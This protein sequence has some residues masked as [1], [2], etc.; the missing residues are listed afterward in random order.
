MANILIA[1]CGDL[2]AALGRMFCEN[3][4]QVWGIRRRA[5]AVPAPIK[6]LALDL[7]EPLDP[8]RLPAADVVFYTAAAGGADEEAY[9]RAY[10]LGPRHLIAALA[11]RAPRRIFFSSSTRVYH[12]SGGEWVDEQSPTRPLDFRGR[13][14]LRGEAEILGAPFPGTVVRFSGLYGP[15][16]YRLVVSAAAGAH[17]T[18]HPPV[19]GNRIHRRDAARVLVHLAALARPESIYLAS[20]SDPAPMHEVSTWIRERLR[21]SGV[22]DAPLG[23]TP[24]PIPRNSKRCRNQRLL[25][26]GFHFEYP[27]YRDG[28]A[29]IIEAWLRE[30]NPLLFNDLDG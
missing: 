15:G 26:G 7:A 18:I 5:E 20:D 2:G 24:G 30:N 27:S 11:A 16:R 9:H 23:A 19:Y 28:Y 3:G 12:Q 14:M 17:G 22:T 10:V 13:V 4:H 6:G 29:P 25:A 21:R 1:G 8:D